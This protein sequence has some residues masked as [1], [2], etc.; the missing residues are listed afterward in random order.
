MFGARCSIG[1]RGSLHGQ[2]DPQCSTRSRAS[3]AA[4]T[5]L[6]CF[7]LHGLAVGLIWN[8]VTDL[9]TELQ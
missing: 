2:R 4:L 8:V 6:T 5:A 9:E 7:D 3:S 1:L